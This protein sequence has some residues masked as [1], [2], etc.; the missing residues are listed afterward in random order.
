L[1]LGEIPAAID[2]L[3]SALQD[4]PEEIDISALLDW[5]L[6][7]GDCHNALGDYDAAEMDYQEVLRQTAKDDV[8]TQAVAFLGLA[9]VAEARSHVDEAEEHY[10]Q[11]LAVYVPQLSVAVAS[12][13]EKTVLVKST[14]RPGLPFGNASSWHPLGEHLSV[15][16]YD[17]E[18]AQEQPVSLYGIEVPP[19][20]ANP[21]KP[22]EAADE[23]GEAEPP[24]FEV[25]L[26]QA[27]PQLA[28]IWMGFAGLYARTDRMREA[29]AC[30]RLA[31]RIY[32]DL[33]IDFGAAR[34]LDLMRRVAG[35]LSNADV[36]EIIEAQEQVLQRARDSRN[37]RLEITILKDL[38][39]CYL[40]RYK[41]ADAETIYKDLH[42][43]GVELEN[44][45]LMVNSEIGLARLDWIRDKPDVAISRLERLIE[46]RQQDL[47]L[48]TDI[49]LLLG[50]IELSR[51]CRERAVKF[52]RK[53]SRGYS[54]L[55]L[56]SQQIEVD[57]LLAATAIETRDYD[58]AVRK[59][60]AA[61]ELARAM[62]IKSLIT[63][64]LCDLARAHV[65]AGQREAALARIEE[66]AETACEIELPYTQAEALMAIGDIRANLKDFDPAERAYQQ[67]QDIYERVRDLDGQIGVFLGLSWL[68]YLAGKPDSALH[69]ARAAW[70]MI[71][72]LDDP[73][74]ARDARMELATALSDC[75]FHAEAIKHLQA[76]VD[77]KPTA[78][79]V[80]NFGWVLYA[81]G[82][83]TR[84]LEQ[85]RRALQLDPAATW[86][87]RNL[88]HA[89]LASGKPDDAEREYKR[90]IQIRKGGEDFFESIRVVR[91]LLSEKPDLPKG[92]EMLQ[93]L[94]EEQ[95]AID[96]R[97]KAGGASV[98]T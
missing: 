65:S 17:L 89:Y 34:A 48:Q 95:R 19:D 63:S 4:P 91:K 85:S 50:R 56:L 96:S 66:A 93:M 78:I 12:E 77:E 82:E 74:R 86:V 5:R 83:Y 11:A 15:V 1:A 98:A 59:L 40:E 81:A 26:V 62:G 57:R 51:D 32:E 14:L 46:H 35:L 27:T 68:H 53:A 6:A 88:A 71:S 97:N 36:E 49:D 43:H 75:G 13:G 23:T 79:T 8:D 18:T 45:S 39:D 3:W 64:V 31:G 22:A 29:A 52:F 61:A 24:A 42:R 37:R 7:L 28:D 67:A 44:P 2:H 76:I 21:S 94:E 84:S 38:A 69:A 80:G 25:A 70:Q 10:R 72:R 92:R 90:A 87:I 55:G 47:R 30:G 33:Q 58:G 16:A 54:I 9:S 73:A 20:V 60:Q 41:Y